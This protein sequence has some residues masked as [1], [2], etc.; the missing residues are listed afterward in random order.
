M[1]Y[2]LN[3]RITDLNVL[4]SIVNSILSLGSGNYLL[5]LHDFMQYR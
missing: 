3:K 4:L 2:R 5:D 1:R